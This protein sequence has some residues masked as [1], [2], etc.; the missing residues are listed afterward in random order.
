MIASC[1]LILEFRSGIGLLPSERSLSAGHSTGKLR[2]PLANLFRDEAFLL[3]QDSEGESALASEQDR[4]RNHGK[5]PNGA[6]HKGDPKSEPDAM[7]HLAVYE[8]GSDQ[9]NQSAGDEAGDSGV[10]TC[11]RSHNQQRT[12]LRGF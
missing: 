1:G 12:R 3:M 9:R 5:Y 4:A 6:G 8:N 2:Q 7:R 11:E 10:K